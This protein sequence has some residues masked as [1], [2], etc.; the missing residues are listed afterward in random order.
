MIDTYDT[1]NGARL[2]IYDNGGGIPEDILEKIFDPYFSTK[3]EKNGTGLGLYM[4]KTIVE[5]HHDGK[6]YA[7]NRDSGVC[8]FLDMKRTKVTAPISR[9]TVS[10]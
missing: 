3:H 8:F 4:S 5:T 9:E 6:F 1:E 2:E 10:A 7:E